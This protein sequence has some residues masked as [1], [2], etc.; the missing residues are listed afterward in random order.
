MTSVVVIFIVNRRVK[1]VLCY[2]ICS[3]DICETVDY[4]TTQILVKCLFSEERKDCGYRA[5]NV[6]RST[7]FMHQSEQLK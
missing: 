2:D 5:G 3:C 4:F 6:Y 7:D 1:K